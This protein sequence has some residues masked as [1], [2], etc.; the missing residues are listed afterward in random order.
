MSTRR[1]RATRAD[2]API[3]Q[4]APLGGVTHDH[5]SGEDRSG[6]AAEFKANISALVAATIGYS[7]GLQYAGYMSSLFAPNLIAEFGWTRSQFALI[8][9]AVFFLP[10]WF[11]VVGRLTDLIGIRRVALFGILGLPASYVALSFMSG[12]LTLFFFLIAVQLI[13]GAM[14]SSTVY[15]RVAVERFAKARGLALT[16]ITCGPALLAAVTVPLLVYII[17]I[18]GWRA[19][20]L[21]LAGLMACA[22]L[23]AFCFL[24]DSVHSNRTGSGKKRRVWADTVQDYKEVART[25]AF[26]IIA[27]A[28]MLCLLPTSLHTSQMKLMLEGTGAP[29]TYVAIAVSG[30]AIGTICGRVSCGLALDRFPAH[31][32]AWVTMLLPAGGYLLLTASGGSGIAVL[33]AMFVVGLSFG[34]ESDLAPYLVSRLFRVELFGTVFSLIIAV[35]SLSTAI[36]ATLLSATLAFQDSYEPF[37]YFSSAAVLVGSGF[38]LLLRRPLENKAEPKV[39]AAPAE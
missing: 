9:S 3:D 1:V 31:Y 25:P 15:T 29:A 14:T 34:A 18:H 8:G 39:A 16:V 20:Y 21:V 12:S 32:V 11:P 27:G 28:M 38:F 23:G 33:L 35:L 22:G 30:F 26:W 4:A 7:V 5:S 17:D 19:G 2:P 10:L 6:Y 24:P 37:L 36:G 13:V